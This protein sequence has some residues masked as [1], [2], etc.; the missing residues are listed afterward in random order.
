M[1]TD[2]FKEYSNDVKELVLAFEDAQRCGVN[3]YYDMDQMEIIID[4][5]LENADGDMLEKSVRYGER[6]FPQ[7][8]EMKLRRAH[9]LC[10]KEKYDDALA[11]LKQLIRM[12]PDN[13]DVLYAMGTV[14]SALDRPEKAIRYYQQASSDGYELDTIYCNI[15]EEYEKMLDYKTAKMYYRKA[16]KTNPSSSRGLYGLYFNYIFAEEY[17]D[18]I[19]FFSAFVNEHPYE[20]IAWYCLGNAF[21]MAGLYEKALD[22]YEYTLAIEPS[23]LDAYLHQGYAYNCLHD[24]PKAVSALLEGLKYADDK[25]S[26]YCRVAQLFRDDGNQITAISY[27]QHAL[28]EDSYYEEAWILLALCLSET[29]QHQEAIDAANQAL[30]INSQSPAILASAAMIFAAS[31][32][33]QAAEELFNGVVSLFPEMESNR[34]SFAEYLIGK[35]RYEEAI[36]LLAHGLAESATP[37]ELHKRQAYCYYVMGRRNLLFDAVRA[38][39]YDQP[40]GGNQLLEYCPEMGS[41]LDVMNI[42]TSY[43]ADNEESHH[44]DL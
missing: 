30:R 23:F 42:I 13:T 11:I 17:H 32:D 8:N 35:Q 10:M 12:E 37:I 21:S 43:K 20:H 19:D 29:G 22:A 34:I 39:L 24:T 44:P 41:D 27:L 9:L 3:Q 14:Y 26:I 2:R 40:D 31:G 38:C 18:A 15:G 7:S 16:L 25:A 1:N 5:Y 28:K 36:D 33:D 4:F 6:L